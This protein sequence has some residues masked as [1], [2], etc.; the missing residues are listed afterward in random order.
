MSFG[1][2]RTDRRSVAEGESTPAMLSTAP[3]R[4]N[5]PVLYERL[6]DHW[7]RPDGAFAALH[8]LAASRVR[9]IGPP[10]REGAVLV[11]LACGGGL[12]APHLR[13]PRLAGYRHVGVDLVASALEHARDAGV[14]AVQGD[15]TALPLADG[16]ADVVV[17]GEIFEHVRDLPAV[18]AEIARVLR[19]GGVVVADT[20]SATRRAR[21]AHVTVGERVPG[22]PPP[23][24]HDPALFVR[25][26]RLRSLFAVH[27]IEM[28]VRGLRPSVPDYARFLVSRRAPVRMLPTRSLAAV[29][30]AVGRKAAGS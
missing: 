22:G 15:V 17:A 12:M 30:Q 19:P 23:G 20:I 2:R 24:C 27:S 16:I 28:T 11:D 29:Y 18:V 14:T 26:D 25:P 4:P 13:T 5:D 3:V 6:A 10:A 1:A 9:L 8:W 21:V 7:W